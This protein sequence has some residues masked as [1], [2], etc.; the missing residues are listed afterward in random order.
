M[1]GTEDPGLI[2]EATS[3]LKRAVALDPTYGHAHRQLGIAFYRRGHL[4]EADLAT[5]EANFADGNVKQ[6][7]IFAKRSVLKLREGSPEWLRAQ[8]IIKYKDVTT[9]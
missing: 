7:Q 6:A 8:D 2:D 3:L 9:N 5:A 1:L 4:P